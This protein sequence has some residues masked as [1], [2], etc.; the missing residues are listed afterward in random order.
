[1]NFSYLP[2]QKSQNEK[3]NMQ[4]WLEGTE[5]LAGML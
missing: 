4:Y 5:E 2:S 1:M 3:E